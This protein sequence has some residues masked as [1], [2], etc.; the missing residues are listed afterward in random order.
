MNNEIK[1]YIQ[2][3]VAD[4]DQQEMGE[5]SDILDE[6]VYVIKKY[7]ENL[8]KEYKMCL[9]RM[10]Y[11]DKLNRDMAEDIVYKMK[12]YGMRWSLEDTKQIQK[13]YGLDNLDE[14][15][16]FVVIN[17]AFNDYR[18]LFEDNIEMYVR[19]TKDFIEDED[20]KQ[21]KVFKYFTQ[22]VAN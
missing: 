8:F 13:D 22:I 20:A 6:V 3:I 1:S 14:L 11:G 5:L 18:N 4:G 21:G 12:P 9:Y 17:S 7:D 19:F 2:K 16:F 15:E 10:A